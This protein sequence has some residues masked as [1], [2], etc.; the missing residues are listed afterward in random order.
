M[1]CEEELRY[2]VVFFFLALEDVENEICC[3]TFLLQ[4]HFSN[5]KKKR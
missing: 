3:R 1:F 2:F 5:F 4:N